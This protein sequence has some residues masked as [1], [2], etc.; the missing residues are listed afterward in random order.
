MKTACCFAAM[1]ILG[2]MR[3]SA[4]PANGTEPPPPVQAK[5]TGIAL[6]RTVK[7]L[8]LWNGAEYQQV[9]FYPGV[10]SRSV[11]Y[12]GPRKISLFEQG[13]N[14]EGEIIYK[15]LVSTELVGDASDYLLFV[16]RKSDSGAVQLVAIPEDLT[17]FG[18]GAFR[19]VNIS[20]RNLAMKL[21]DERF[22]IQPMNFA[23]VRG[24]FESG[25]S[26]ESVIV[27]L[28]RDNGAP[29][30]LYSSSIYYNENVRMLYL[31]SF[32]EGSSKVRLTGIPQ[33]R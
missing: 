11:R 10:R 17:D 13:T 9:D 8:Y 18:V 1:L 2:S 32:Q 30:V 12:A 16:S 26:Q 24:D 3:L 4:Q 25:T 5:L 6:E 23:D 29:K 31:I 21:G 20:Q 15:P 19:F 14:A 28:P 7:D 27:E 33:K 22:A